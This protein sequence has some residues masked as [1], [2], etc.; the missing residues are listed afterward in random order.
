M[1]FQRRPQ[2]ILTAMVLS[3]FVSAATSLIGLTA[4][5]WHA[6]MGGVAG[7]DGSRVENQEPPEPRQDEELFMNE[8]IE[9]EYFGSDESDVF[10]LPETPTLVQIVQE[11]IGQLQTVVDHILGNPEAV[12]TVE[13]VITRLRE[14]LSGNLEEE[15]PEILQEIHNELTGA[16]EI[17]EQAMTR[18]AAPEAQMSVELKSDAAYV[19]ARM[20]H[21][22]ETALPQVFSI[23]EY[24]GLS[25]PA[26]T[27]QFYESSF[28]KFQTEAVPACDA[29]KQKCFELLRGI[30][31]EL[32]GNVRQ[33][34]EMLVVESGNLMI[35]PAIEALFKE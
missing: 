20:R 26:M 31:E 22:L 32:D 25:L 18:S 19:I 3:A 13:N 7:T 5:E 14:R 34:I 17:A 4:L 28:V 1:R 2:R 29:G 33:P 23:L 15:N 16:V 6:A 12:A 27:E 21:V 30:V 8:R 11:A 10:F 24:E 35:G 9:R